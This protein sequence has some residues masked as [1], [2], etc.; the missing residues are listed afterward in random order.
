MEITRRSFGLATAG[1][2]LLPVLPAAAKEAPAGTQVPGIY[3][4]KVGSYEVTIL[5]DGT[6]ALPTKYYSGDPAGAAKLLE[7]A[8]APSKEMAP[9]SF[10]EWLINTGDKL[11]LVDTGYSNGIGPVAGHLPKALATAGVNPADIDAVVVTHVHPDHCNGLLTTDKQIAFPNATVNINGDEFAWWMEGDVKVPEGKPFF[12]E[13]FEGGRAVF[14]PY[15]D[16]KRVQTFKDGAELAPGVTAVTAPGHTVGHTMMRVTSG[17][18][19]LLIWTDIVHST[20]LQFPEPER[21]IA[22][23]LDPPQAI[24]TR[25]KVMDMVSTD[26]VTIAGTHI[27]FPGVGHVAKAGSGYAFVPVPWN[28]EPL[29]ELSCRR[30]RRGSGDAA[31]ALSD[32][33]VGNEKTGAEKAPRREDHM[34]RLWLVALA[35]LSVAATEPAKAQVSDDVVKIGV[36]TDMSGP[37]SAADGPGSVAAAQ[38]AVDDFGGTVL[39][40][41]IQIISADHQIKPDIAAGIARQWYDRDQVDLIVDVP[42]SAVGLAVQNVANES[43][44]LLIVHSTGTADFHGKFC[45]PYALQWV[46][47]TRALAVGTAQE[48]TK[49]GGKSWFFLTADYAFGHALERDASAVIVAE[50]RQ[51]GRLGAASFRHA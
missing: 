50:R 27:G 31:S 29:A 3:R 2:A 33:K 10:N 21:S 11:V 43:K 15:V 30:E 42:V 22:F 34:Q 17:N 24:A 40:K 13:L 7:N 46:F 45:N 28:G 5:N 49:R 47:D 44:R 48:V 12:K 8:F 26:R 16:G 51:R 41:P 18:D 6:A 25:K 14:K 1:A 39:G 20:A 19:Q 36:L 4:M 35:A 23:D 37:S 32:R 38:M 9:T